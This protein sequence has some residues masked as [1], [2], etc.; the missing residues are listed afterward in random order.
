VDPPFLRRPDPQT[1]FTTRAQRFRQLASGRPAMAGYL[2][3]MAELAETQHAALIDVYL[4]ARPEPVRLAAC[5]E[6]PARPFDARHVSYEEW[7]RPLRVLCHHLARSGGPFADIIR[8]IQAAVPME[9]EAWAGSILSGDWSE[10][11]PGAAPIIAAALQVRWAAMLRRLGA[12]AS[13][14]PQEENLCPLCGSPPVASLM[15][16]GGAVQ[17]LRYLCCSLCSS[18]WNLP[19]VRC[20]QCG[21]AKSV[22]YYRVEGW[23]DAVRAEGCGDCETYLK[24]LNLEKDSGLDPFADDLATLPLDILMAEQGFARYGVNPFLIPGQYLPA[25]HS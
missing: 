3:L 15:T 19:R 23:G 5:P 2:L 13:E 21:S 24:I 16:S 18:Q 25:P 1:L 11:D 22:A 14:R 9:L 12:A 20:T 10:P 4:K 17:G 6:Q 7:S 8:R